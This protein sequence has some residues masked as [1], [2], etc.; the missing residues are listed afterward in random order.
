MF[1]NAPNIEEIQQGSHKVI[2]AEAIGKATKVEDGSFPCSI[3]PNVY[4]HCPPMLF[5]VICYIHIALMCQCYYAWDR[6][7]FM[8]DILDMPQEYCLSKLIFVTFFLRSCHKMNALLI[9]VVSAF[10]VNPSGISSSVVA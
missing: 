5:I 1:F 7:K 8:F 4:V 6:K 3:L 9:T 2:M 10:P